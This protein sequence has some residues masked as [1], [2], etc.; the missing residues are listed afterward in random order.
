[1]PMTSNRPY[2]LRA[3][4]EWIID[5]E[6][7][8]HLVVDAYYPEVAVP[9]QY[10]TNGQITLNIAPR[11]VATLDLGNEAVFFNTRFG[12]IPTDV[13]VPVKAVLGIFAKENG[14]GMMFEPEPPPPAPTDGPAS[15]DSRTPAPDKGA[16][17]RPR[18][19]SLKVVK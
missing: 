12:G 3:F 2:L 19:P 4:Y 11:A 10:V 7:T 5:N 17:P 14:H 16:A 9:Q 6:M 15:A 13:F 18:K 8:P 1:M